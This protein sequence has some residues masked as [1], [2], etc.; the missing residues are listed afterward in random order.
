M[1]GQAGLL[2]ESIDLLLTPRGVLL[3]DCARV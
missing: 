2:F 1:L 3:T